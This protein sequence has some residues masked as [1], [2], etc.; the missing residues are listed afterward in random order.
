MVTTRKFLVVLF[1][2]LLGVALIAMPAAGRSG[3]N[4]EKGRNRG[5]TPTEGN[6]ASPRSGNYQGSPKN[7]SN[8][9]GG[10][11]DKPVPA[12]QGT[13]DWDWN[14][15][16]GND[17]DRD[18]DNNG[19]CGR[20]HEHEHARERDRDSEQ[21]RVMA[22]GGQRDGKKGAA[23]R[24][25]RSG[26]LGGSGSEVLGA[27][28]AAAPA[29]T[30]VLGANFNRNA[31]STDVLGASGGSTDVLGAGFDALPVTGIPALIAGLA[32]LVLTLSGGLLLNRR[33][34]R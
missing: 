28:G 30:Q 3:D 26:A 9:D 2:S 7:Q 17:D 33:D 13:S 19:W 31:P 8:P 18:D 14:N 34:R 27:G 11:I 16:C 23:V 22:A 15:G 10:G 24:A 12:T 4:A 1:A 32:G 5:Y 20:K 6:S 29:S 25:G 21:A